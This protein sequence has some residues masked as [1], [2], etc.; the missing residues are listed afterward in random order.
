MNLDGLITRQVEAEYINIDVE[1]WIGIWGW[2]LIASHDIFF[3]ISLTE[4]KYQG[5]GQ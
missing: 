3:W 5:P 4:L 2:L 1:S